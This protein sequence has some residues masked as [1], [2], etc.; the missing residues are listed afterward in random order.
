MS[1]GRTGHIAAPEVE[2]GG[3][4]TESH[5]QEEPNEVTSMS[6]LKKGIL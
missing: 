2:K 4:I 3:C 6:D 5:E 1:P